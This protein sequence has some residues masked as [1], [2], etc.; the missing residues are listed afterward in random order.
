[1]SA[2]ILLL[3]AGAAF[4]MAFVLVLAAIFTSLGRRMGAEARAESAAVKALLMEGNY[5]RSR[6]SNAAIRIAHEL[7]QNGAK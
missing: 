1:M 7:E 4:G 3:L 6:L 5:E 2:N